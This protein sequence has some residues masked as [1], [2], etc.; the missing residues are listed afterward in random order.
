MDA[1]NQYEPYI[2]EETVNGYTQSEILTF[3]G[4]NGERYYN[5]FRKHEKKKLF[6]HMNWSACILT[7]YW[8]F[9]RKMYVEGILYLL[10]TKVVAVVAILIAFACFQGEW[11]DLQN[12]VLD[13]NNSVE[14]YAAGDF[15]EFPDF[16]EASRLNGQRD[17]LFGKMM[18][19]AIIPGV[20][21]MVGLGLTADCLYR[22]YMLKKIRFSGGGTSGLSILAALGI[23]IVTNWADNTFI[24]W[25]VGLIVK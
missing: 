10:L 13:Y 25:L 18:F 21:L 9:Y 3:V 17:M 14:Q 16:A 5:L 12:Q 4:S 15:S 20:V 22:R 23:V 11:L 8:M 1:F 19:V 6:F 2:P 7:I 24:Q